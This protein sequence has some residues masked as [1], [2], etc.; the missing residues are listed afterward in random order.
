M[1]T[2]ERA[3]LINAIGFAI[4]RWQDA[5]ED[6]DSAVGEIYGL[7]AAERRCL[8]AVSHG[9]QPANAIAKATNLT[10]AAVTTLIDRL[11]SRGFVYRQPDPTDRRRVLVVAAARTE[12]I[13]RRAYRPVFEAGAKLL[14]NF[15]LAEMRL[16]LRFIE[17]VE[18]MQ[19]AQITRLRTMAPNGDDDDAA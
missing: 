7:S 13:T 5:V 4:S 11:A 19:A 18:A 12:E 14:D 6:F 10:P 9:P 3:D 2:S 16:I 17:E 15:S 1:S 8:G